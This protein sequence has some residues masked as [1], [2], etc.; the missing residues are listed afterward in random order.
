MTQD[1]ENKLLRKV[2]DLMELRDKLLEQ[3]KSYRDMAEKHRRLADESS[4]NLLDRIIGKYK[5]V[6]NV[7][8]LLRSERINREETYKLLLM[9]M[10]NNA[11]FTEAQALKELGK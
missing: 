3:N 9:A 4:W 5:T 6:H 2:V 8:G 11:Q 7:L 1:E 10:K